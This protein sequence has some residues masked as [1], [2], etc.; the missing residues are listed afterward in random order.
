MERIDHS[1]YDTRQ[2][3]RST[4]EAGLRELFAAC[5]DPLPPKMEELLHHLEHRDDLD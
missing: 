4:Y 5:H 1:H 2:P 3:V